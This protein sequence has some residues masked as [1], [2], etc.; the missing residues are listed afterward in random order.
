MLFRS[1]LTF[2]IVIG[3]VQGVLAVLAVLQHG[4]VYSDLMR[5][6]IAVISQTT[7][8]AYQ[9]ILELGLP[10][11]MIRNGN[12]FV[13]RALEMDADIIAVHALEPSGTV[14][15][16]TADPPPARV[17]P[18]V[19]ER[20]RYATG[21]A[22][23]LETEREIASGWILRDEGGAPAAAVVVDYP[24]DRF[25]AASAA[26]LRST[27]TAAAVIWLVF[28]AL[29][30]PLL[31]M[32]LRGPR[33]AIRWL[34]DLAAKPP[35]P[36]KADSRSI[37]DT[38]IALLETRLDDAA[39]C[40]DEATRALAAV[41]ATGNPAGAAAVGPSRQAVEPTRSLAHILATR[42]APAAAAVIVASALS[43]GFVILQ[44]ENRS[45]EPEL[46]ARTHLIGEVVSHNV[47]RAVAAGA[48][49]DQLVGAEHYFGDMLQHLPSVAYIAVATG[50][51]VMEAGE[52]IDPYLAP[53]RQRKGVRSHPVMQDGEELAYVVIDIDQAVIAKRFRDV[54]LDM[55]VVILVTVMIAYEIMVLLTSRS[56]TAGLDRLQR[57][58]SLQAAGDFSRTLAA[59]GRGR[60][61]S[62]TRTLASRAEDLYGAF[63]RARA[64]AG[65]AGSAALGALGRRYGLGEGAPKPLRF[66]QFTDIRLALF[67]FAAADELPLA[68]LP[69]YTRQSVNLWPWLDETLVMSLPLAGYLLTILFASPFAR[70]LSRRLGVRRL[71][72]V[73]AIPLV[74]A[75]LGL[76][77][78]G[79][80]QEIMLWRAVSGAGYALITLACNDYVL[81]NAPPGQRDSTLGV[82][83]LV[84]YG[85][86]FSGVAL[87]GVLAD[88]LGQANVFLLSAAMVA[89][90][91][92]L[93]VA[94][95]A[96]EGT[97]E[98]AG[99]RPAERFSLRKIFA[100]LGDARFAAVSMGIS[101]PAG[102]VMQAFICYLVAITLDARGYS[103][104]DTG[105]ALMLYFL[106]VVAAGPVGGRLALHGVPVSL[107]AFGGAA[108]AG[109]SLAAFSVLRGDV[110]L[111]AVMAFTGLGFGL[112]R[113]AQVSMAMRLA[114]EGLAHLGSVAVLGALRTLERLGSVV[115]LLVV[116]TVAGT[117]G[118]AA[119]TGV[120]AVWALA[121]AVAFLSIYAIRYLTSGASR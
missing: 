78:A 64:A 80:A 103:T 113:G 51:I 106:S 108:A 73:A 100:P 83:T 95:I 92:V 1:W 69:L 79:T 111:I 104:A 28:A 68:F 31:A 48:P 60:I 34:D 65:E 19:L 120:L 11:S 13:A 67:L 32:L 42:L 121:G 33:R 105:R 70:T 93:S 40:H 84:L 20:M 102:V 35:D 101:I 3:V 94:F 14:V 114:E 21:N 45:I 110:V 25:A 77:L 10:I 58:A 5:Q 18:Q 98:S 90:S 91:V 72:V 62:L 16:S 46:A 37:F 26:V 17:A 2:A 23:S 49:L 9:P 7:A 6:R 63:E 29:S 97:R 118:Y 56:L 27:L 8:T 44:S 87:G 109:V 112:V 88:R 99:G 15:H 12:E 30:Y 66:S 39:R 71:F 50:G 55:L 53:P 47:E 89:A 59:R 24:K 36:S 119:A 107:V 61:A 82:F 81:D 85:G 52:R 43:L 74:G 76:Y 38:E 57:L 41:P 75:H 96:P 22:F 86:I 4:A 54:F 115:G 117:A 116:A